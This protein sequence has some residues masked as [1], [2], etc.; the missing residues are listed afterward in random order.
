MLILPTHLTHR[1]PS[2]IIVPRL[3]RR[4][5]RAHNGAEKDTATAI[6]DNKE[7]YDFLRSTSNK[8]GIGFWGPGA[9]IMHQVLL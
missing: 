7:V 1:R 4:H 8:Y 9:G 2:E 3:D 6:K 5:L